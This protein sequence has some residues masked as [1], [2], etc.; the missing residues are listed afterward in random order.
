MM[1]NE[2][3]SEEEKKKIRDDFFANEKEI[4]RDLRRRVT[5]TDFESLSIV[6]RGAFG[7]VF[8]FLCSTFVSQKKGV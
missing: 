4:M 1:A 3:L 8:F 6:G 5:V 7:E 2:A